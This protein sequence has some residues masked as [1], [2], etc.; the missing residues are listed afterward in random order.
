MP[1]CVLNVQL[2]RGV[3]YSTSFGYCSGTG[4]KPNDLFLYENQ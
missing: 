2:P 4:P 1:V 3:S